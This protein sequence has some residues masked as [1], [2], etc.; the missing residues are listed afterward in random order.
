M[1]VFGGIWF[2]LHACLRQYNFGFGYFVGQVIL[3]CWFFGVPRFVGFDACGLS[4][5]LSDCCFFVALRS[6]ARLFGM[7]D[8]R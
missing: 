6:E 3:V 7:R 4:L 2:G 5:M 1:F 8:L